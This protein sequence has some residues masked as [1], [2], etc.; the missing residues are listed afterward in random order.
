M[1]IN[2]REPWAAALAIDIIADVYGRPYKEAADIIATRLERLRLDGER[3]GLIEAIN[4]IRGE[5]A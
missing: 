5:A 3:A 2:N 4:V 1:T